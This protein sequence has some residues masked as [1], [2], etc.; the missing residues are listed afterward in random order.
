MRLTLRTM[1]AYMDEILEPDDAEDIG[2]KIHESEFATELLQKTRDC[3]SR[4]RL[5]APPLAGRGIALDANTVAEYLDNTLAGERVPDFEKVCLESDMHLAEVAGCH[6]VLTV[7]VLGEAADVE[8]L[9]RDRM[10]Q[11][12]ASAAASPPVTAPPVGVRPPVPPIQAQVP[13]LIRRPKPEVPEYLRREPRS[14][15][16]TI[17][18][19]AFLIGIILGGGAYCGLPR[20]SIA[21]ASLRGFRPRRMTTRQPMMP[22]RKMD[23]TN[24]LRQNKKLNRQLASQQQS[25]PLPPSRQKPRQAMIRRRIQMK[26]PATATPQRTM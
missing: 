13:P 25:R 4:V 1:L 26:W 10:Y 24:P 19:A 16:W 9:D 7:V 23:R 5:G 6:Q 11:L 15:I 21:N 22:S 17:A 8:S 14:R 18:V 3:V 12:P 2:K 20:L